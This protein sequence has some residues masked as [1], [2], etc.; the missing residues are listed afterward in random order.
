MN[1][2]EDLSDFADAFEHLAEGFRS[3]A[4]QVAQ[5]LRRRS[6]SFVLVTTPEPD[7]VDAT[8][9]FHRELMQE[10]FHV[11]GTIANRV[12][13]FPPGA[14]DEVGRYPVALR[15]K[16][17]TNYADFVSLTR[18]DQHGLA[19]IQREMR[20]PIL[21]TIPVLEQAPVSL[22]RLEHFAARLTADGT[23]DG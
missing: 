7:T 16:L 20:R 18:R 14:D 21:A 11:G 8:I 19:R 3:R 4:E 9:A 17:L 13:A 23:G 2:L 1:V 6:T 10:G 5:A 15:R 12:H 22:A